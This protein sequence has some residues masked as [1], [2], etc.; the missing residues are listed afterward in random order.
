MKLVR[1]DIALN[2]LF[3]DLA[4]V[5]DSTHGDVELTVRH[6]IWHRVNTAM[7]LEDHSWDEFLQE[8]NWMEKI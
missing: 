5:L 2:N 4:P 7:N 3:E 1:D 6:A 8:S